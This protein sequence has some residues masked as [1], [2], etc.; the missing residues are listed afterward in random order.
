MQGYTIRL[1]YAR[2]CEEKLE[3]LKV[4]VRRVLDP[5]LVYGACRLHSADLLEGSI[6]EIF[7]PF[8]N[9]CYPVYH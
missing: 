2:I 4:Y 5:K 7:L 3:Y 8:D 6:K 9:N 1:N